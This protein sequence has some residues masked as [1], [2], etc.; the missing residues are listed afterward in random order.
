MRNLLQAV[1]AMPAAKA[2]RRS[3]IVSALGLMFALGVMAPAPAAYASASSLSASGERALQNLYAVEPQ[4]RFYARH[5]KAILIFP[6]V[7]KGAFVFGGET[8]NGVLLVHGRPMGFYNT[9]AASWG[10]QAGGK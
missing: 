4:A 6:G 3:T 5:A 1:A 9:S 7:I 2:S 8:G 10:L